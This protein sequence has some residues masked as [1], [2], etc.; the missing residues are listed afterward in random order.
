MLRLLTDEEIE[1]YEEAQMR[2][3]EWQK[4]HNV[5]IDPPLSRY[6]KMYV[7]SKFIQTEKKLKAPKLNN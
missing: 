1:Q 6:D 5:Y 2:S 3:F 7:F 4:E